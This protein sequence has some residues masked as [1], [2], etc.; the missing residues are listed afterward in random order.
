[1]SGF[2]PALRKSNGATAMIPRSRPTIDRQVEDKRPQAPLPDN[3]KSQVISKEAQ[4]LNDRPAAKGFAV[5]DLDGIAFE[6]ALSDLK[7]ALGT[8]DEDFCKG[9]LVQLKRLTP[10][11]HGTDQ[12]DFNFVLSVLKDEK[13]FNKLHAMQVVQMAVV[14]LAAMTQSQILVKPVR[15]ELPADFQSAIQNAKWDTSRLDKQKIKFDDQPARQVGERIVTRLMQTFALQLQASA[16]Y[17]KS[18]AS[19]VQQVSAITGG[20]ALLTGGTEAVPCKA[21]KAAAAQPSRG[22]NGSRQS[23][24]PPVINIQKSNGHPSS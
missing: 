11:G 8:D 16:A 17:R 14:H 18:E 2:W 3:G 24:A 6:H 22:L 23:A 1:M 21:Q 20:P 13:P 5:E 9:I 15:F 7:E 12:T 10:Y 19:K 4:G